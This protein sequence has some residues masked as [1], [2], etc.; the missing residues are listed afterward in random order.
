MFLLGFMQ[1]DA[2]KY[3]SFDTGYVFGCLGKYAAVWFLNL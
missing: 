2:W 3:Y 1:D